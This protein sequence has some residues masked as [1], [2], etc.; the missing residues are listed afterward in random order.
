M[1]GLRGSGE[2]ALTSEAEPGMWTGYDLS[3]RERGRHAQ[4]H[5]Q[6]TNGAAPAPGGE[7]DGPP[8]RS[9]YGQFR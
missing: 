6:G 8:D 7:S 4:R 2:W 1:T 5:A 3:E 9:R